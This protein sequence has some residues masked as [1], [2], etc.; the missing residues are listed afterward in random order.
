MHPNRISGR[1]ADA[2]VL[3]VLVALVAAVGLL[4]G[5]GGS[6]KKS[7][8]SSTTSASSSAT[9]SAATSAARPRRRPRRP[10]RRQRRPAAA[11]SWTQPNAQP[12]RHARRAVVDQLVQRLQ[13]RRRLDGSDHRQARH[14][15]ATSRRRRWSST[16][17]PTSRT[18]TRA[19]TRSSMRPA[20]CSGTRQYNSPNE[21]PDGVNVVGGKVYGATAS[22][23]FALSA[24][25]GEQLWS[26]KLIRNKG[27][28]IDMAPAV[29]DGTVYVST[30]PGNAKGFYTGDGVAVLWAMN[31]ATGKVKWKWNEV[32][33]SLWGNKKVNSGGGQ[34]AAPDVRLP[35]PPVPRGRQ[36]GPVRRRQV[37]SGQEGLPERVQPSRAEPVHRHGRRAQPS[38][39]ETHLALPADPARHPRL[40]PQQPGA[41]H[42]RS[43][44]RRRSSPPARPGS[45][46]PTTPRPA[47]C[48]GRP[49]S[50]RTTA[51]TTTASNTIH[52]AT[53]NPKVKEPPYQIEPGR[54]RR[55]RE[56]VRVRRDD[57]VLPGQQLQ[58]GA[59]KHRPG[60]ARIRDAA[61]GVMVAIDQATGKIKWQHQFSSSPYGAATVSNDLVWTTTFDGTL[62][63]LNKNTGA[64]VWHTKLPAG[65]NSP[66]AIDGD[67]V[68]TGAGFP[69][70]KGQKAT[71]IA[72]RIG[73][74]GSSSSKG[75]STRAR[76]SSRRRAAA[77]RS[78]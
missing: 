66:V 10:P 48:C 29:N 65:T 1:R 55:R 77:R 72:Y 64:V 32:P 23:A 25:T 12:G 57:R 43:T 4:A 19:C 35:G 58:G 27:E 56:P 36:P 69:E 51:T 26:K 30:V 71:F 18:S 59:D 47:S 62:W 20:S 38:H 13:A 41:D 34:W 21:G 2:R 3:G 70:G 68:L 60:R 11:A 46:S 28:G 22:K 50:A 78:A 39:R 53:G 52:S 6:S 8:S 45:R 15:S 74:T 49:R 33:T 17:S 5:C 7:S 31:A 40:G 75:A 42:A 63:A 76:R 54:A 24:A 14:R 16:A 73:A 44:A 67:T 9:T 37:L 61:T